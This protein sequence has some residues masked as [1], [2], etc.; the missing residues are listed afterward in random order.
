MSAGR[1]SQNMAGKREERE[2]DELDE[3]A[4]NSLAV[5]VDKPNSLLKAGRA[6]EVPMKAE[7]YLSKEEKSQLPGRSRKRRKNAP[8]HDGCRSSDD[9]ARVDAPVVDGRRGRAVLDALEELDHVC[10]AGRGGEKERSRSEVR[11]REAE[12]GKGEGVL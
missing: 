11:V 9:S 4:A 7:S 5:F 12:E 3:M 10:E 1:E 8:D 6:M 2:N